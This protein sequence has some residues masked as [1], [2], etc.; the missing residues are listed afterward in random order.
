MGSNPKVS[1][2]EDQ[3]ILQCYSILPVCLF[4]FSRQ[5]SQHREPLRV[6][7]Q[8]VRFLTPVR[9]SVRIE[10]SAPCYPS[11]LQEQDP[12]VASFRDLL[13]SSS[14]SFSYI[15]KSPL[16]IYR[17]NEALKDQVQVQ[18]FPEES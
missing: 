6:D 5:R 7:G 17:E 12:C 15:E 13:S 9:R 1:C 11:A 3:R 2:C 4:Y 8:E 18:L 10:R 14:S 16:Y